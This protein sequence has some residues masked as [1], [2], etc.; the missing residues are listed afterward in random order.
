[1]AVRLAAVVA[2]VIGAGCSR[3]DD[4]DAAR[5]SSTAATAST[6]ADGSSGTG[7]GPDGSPAP[8][9]TLTALAPAVLDPRVAPAVAS[10]GEMVDG[11]IETA[12]GRS[13]SY[14]LYVPSSLPAGDVPLLV[15]LHGGLGSGMQFATSSELTG[16]AEANGF[17]AV[18]PDG[19]PIRD[20]PTRAVWNGGGCCATAAEDREDVD[21][22]AFIGDLI[23]TVVSS[24]AVDPE[25]IVVTGHSNGGILSMRLACELEPRV[26]A[27]AFQAGTL[28]V[29]GCDNDAPVSA[30]AIHG[31]DDQNVLLDGG[32]GDASLDGSD[33]PPVRDGLAALAAAN[34]CTGGPEP[35]VAPAADKAD[36]TVET[37]TGCP[38]GIDVQLLV[39]AGANHAWMG[40]GQAGLS[41]RRIGPAYRD[42]DASE[43]VWAFLAAH[44]R[45]R[46]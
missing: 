19:I 1:V 6:T 37:W 45:A 29:P 31:A 32:A 41:E 24:Y 16:L 43:V 21:D 30:L 18:F 9:A 10:E 5:S 14:H 25:R 36:V 15:G 35:E 44:P 4:E 17:L 40:H 33:Y 20:E 13:R 42:L 27:V 22:V 23:D 39:V 7:A 12:D 38:E 2:L 28:F 26:A 3:S 34:G 46:P 11:V 8:L